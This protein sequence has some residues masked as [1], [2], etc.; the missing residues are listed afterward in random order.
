MTNPWIWTRA[1]IQRKHRWSVTRKRE[2]HVTGST[3]LQKRTPC[4][5][6]QK[7]ASDKSRRLASKTPHWGGRSGRKAKVWFLRIGPPCLVLMRAHPG[8]WSRYSACSWVTAF[9][10]VTMALAHITDNPKKSTTH[11]FG[12]H[13]ASRGICYRS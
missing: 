7:R 8:V 11:G 6:A 4:F 3:T 9:S 2:Q 10:T 5:L 1:G 13:T 12:G